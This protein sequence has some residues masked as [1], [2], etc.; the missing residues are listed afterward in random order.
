[1]KSIVTHTATGNDKYVTTYY[2]RDPQGNVLAVYE[3]KRGETDD[4]VLTL[5]EQHLYGAGRIGMRR[6]NLALN[7]NGADESATPATRY[8]L[9]NHLGNVMAVISDAPSDGAQPTVESL[10][11]YYPFG[12]AMPGRSYNATDYRFGFNGQEKETAEGSYLDYGERLYNARLAKWMTIDPLIMGY[13]ELSPY[14]YCAGNPIT[15][16]DKHGGTIWI[17]YKDKDGIEMRVNFKD[18]EHNTEKL[19]EINNEFVSKTV[20]AFAQI[21]GWSDGDIERYNFSKDIDF[22]R[23]NETYGGYPLDYRI[24]EGIPPSAYPDGSKVIIEIDNKMAMVGKVKGETT[25]ALPPSASLFHEFFEQWRTF[26]QS[27][28]DPNS[29]YTKWEEENFGMYK[30]EKGDSP[31]VK[32]EKDAGRRAKLGAYDTEGDMYVI[33]LLESYIAKNYFGN[34]NELYRDSHRGS[35]DCYEVQDVTSVEP[36]NK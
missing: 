5:T 24:K 13:P 25:V 1:M 11:D 3:R 30:E 26:H 22:V 9:T 27:V 29:D 19:K 2:V 6:R 32:E 15:Y 18:V 28:F 14:S 20:A 4:G 23:D 33:M 8:E 36:K 7:N 16:I 21:K 34:S 10:T 12:M 35:W 17:Y 31:K